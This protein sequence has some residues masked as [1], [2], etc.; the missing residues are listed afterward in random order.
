MLRKLVTALTSAAILASLSVAPQAVA[1]E[2]NMVVSR[3]LHHCRFSGDTVVS[4]S[5]HIIEELST[6]PG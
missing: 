2:R 5:L 6:L 3:R 1:A 4:R